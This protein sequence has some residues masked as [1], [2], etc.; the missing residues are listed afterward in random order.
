[1]LI[2]LIKIEILQFL[3]QGK[4][5]Y[6]SV[7]MGILLKLQFGVMDLLA[8]EVPLTPLIQDFCLFMYLQSVI[9]NGICLQWGKIAGNTRN[10]LINYPIAIQNTCYYINGH[11]IYSSITGNHDYD[12]NFITEQKTGFS[13]YCDPG[14]NV[15]AVQVNWFCI[16]Y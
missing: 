8:M 13:V 9:N 12:P 2:Q 14:G 16:T 4:L 5:L 6:L 15:N 10:V 3:L 11:P 1:M 7:K